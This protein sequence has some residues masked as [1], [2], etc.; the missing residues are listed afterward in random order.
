MEDDMYARW[1]AISAALLG[2][3]YAVD[4]SACPHCWGSSTFFEWQC[5]YTPRVGWS[6]LQTGVGAMLCT[7]SCTTHNPCTTYGVATDW[8]SA[9]YTGTCGGGDSCEDNV[10][11]TPPPPLPSAPCSGPIPPPD[12]EG[13]VW[14]SGMPTPDPGWSYNSSG[15]SN[16]V[17]NPDSGRFLVQMPGLG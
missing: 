3:L 13:W 2:A 10:Y 14:Y 4:A 1:L 17:S 5:R 6:Y 9:D 11:E 12:R 16:L 7:C 8:E 15:A